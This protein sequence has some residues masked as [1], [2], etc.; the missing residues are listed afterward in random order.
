MQ[1]ID[2]KT[3]LQNNFVD[4]DRERKLLAKF[5][6][7]V[8]KRDLHTYVNGFRSL[9]MELGNLVTDETVLW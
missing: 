4:S 5:N 8:Q 7:F 3:E 9:R 6:N 1:W 2:L